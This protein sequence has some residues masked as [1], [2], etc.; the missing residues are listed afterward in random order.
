[1]LALWF[2]P[3]PNLQ[4]TSLYG[5]GNKKEASG[6]E[7]LD[8]NLIFIPIVFSILI[9]IKAICYMWSHKPSA[10]EAADFISSDGDEKQS[11][12]A[13][14]KSWWLLRSLKHN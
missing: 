4:I 12:M 7:S 14:A 6:G 8:L 3:L 11:K 9:Y 1:M 5:Q 10:K 2:F 13:T